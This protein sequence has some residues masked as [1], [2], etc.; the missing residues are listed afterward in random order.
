MAEVIFEFILEIVGEL[1]LVPFF[2]WTVNCST[3]RRKPLICRIPAIITSIVI[4]G[5]MVVLLFALGMMVIKEIWP[6]A[7]VVFAADALL[8]GGIVKQYIKSYRRNVI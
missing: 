2:N 3:D 1:I 7:I 6:L 5:G 8:A 4:Y